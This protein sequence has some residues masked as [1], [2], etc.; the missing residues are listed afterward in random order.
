MKPFKIDV[1]KIQAFCLKKEKEL[2]ALIDKS[3][4]FSKEQKV[5][6]GQYRCAQCR[7]V[8]NLNLDPEYQKQA[9]AEA[10][11]DFPGLENLENAAIVCDDCYQKIRPD[12]HPKEYAEYK[13]ELN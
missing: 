5:G 13:A 11:R 3:C 7:G 1:K 4:G 2:A 8:F 6:P 10:R 9:E 12:T